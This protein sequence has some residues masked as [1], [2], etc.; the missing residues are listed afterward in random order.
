MATQNYYMVNEQTNVC[1]NVVLWDGNP[2]TWTPPPNYLMLAENTTPVKNWF[3]NSVE[4][5]WELLVEGSGSIGYTWDGTYLV[6]NEP[7]PPPI[8]DPVVTGAQT[9]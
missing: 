5:I 4:K 7:E 6:T 2:D 9:L 8:V 1:G 3:W